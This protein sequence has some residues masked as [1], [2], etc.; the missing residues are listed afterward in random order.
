MVVSEKLALTQGRG[1]Q[2]EAEQPWMAAAGAESRL[3]VPHHTCPGKGSVRDRDVPVEVEK[4][5]LC[6]N[7]EDPTKHRTG[8]SLGL[9]LLKGT[10]AVG[11]ETQRKRDKEWV[12]WEA[13]TG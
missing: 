11:I 5:W 9:S 8:R 6:K 2:S 13:V 4:R 12:G 10:T 7:Q 1:D 3:T